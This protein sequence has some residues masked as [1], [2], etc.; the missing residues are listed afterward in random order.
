MSMIDLSA[1][2]KLYVQTA[3]QYCESILKSCHKLLQNPKDKN[4][5]QNIY[6]SAHSIRSQSQVMG[7]CQ[8]EQL[9]GMIE[10]VAK[11]FLGE[12]K[13]IPKDLINVTAEAVKAI[14]A[15]LKNIEAI[16]QERD[17]GSIAKK[18]EDAYSKFFL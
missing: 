4:A 3:G 6:I 1:Y 8:T 13:A 14:I 12:G 15:S 17:T 10:K 16:N 7:Y 18:L 9:S 5:L 11:N 2:K